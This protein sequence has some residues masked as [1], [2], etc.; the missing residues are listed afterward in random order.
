MQSMTHKPTR[1]RFL[2]LTGAGLGAAALGGTIGRPAL[3]K[4]KVIKLG[5]VSPQ[6]GP[7]APFAEADAFVVGERRGVLIDESELSFDVDEFR[8]EALR[9]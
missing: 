8:H 4:D 2:Q 1:R 3:A 9:G 6:T 5:Y 7:L